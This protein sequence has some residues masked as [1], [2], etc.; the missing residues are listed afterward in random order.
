[1]FKDSLLFPFALTI[2]GILIIYLGV[3]YQRHHADVEDMVRDRLPDGLQ[4][5]VPPRVKAMA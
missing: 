2:V 1:V 4:Q 5:M 3:L